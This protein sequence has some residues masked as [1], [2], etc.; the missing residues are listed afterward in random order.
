MYL[1]YSNVGGTI[2]EAELFCMADDLAGSTLLKGLIS[3]YLDPSITLHVYNVERYPEPSRLASRYEQ[4]LQASLPPAL[5]ESLSV[6]S[7]NYYAYRVYIRIYYGTKFLSFYL[8]NGLEQFLPALAIRDRMVLMPQGYGKFLKKM[9]PLKEVGVQYNLH[10]WDFSDEEELTK[11]ISL[12][13][14]EL[15][16]EIR[17]E[18]RAYSSF[19][20]G[21]INVKQVADQLQLPPALLTRVFKEET[22]AISAMYQRLSCDLEQQTLLLGRWTKTVLV[23]RNESDKVFRGVTVK[24]V[25]PIE[26]LPRNI[27]VDLLA[28]SI[29]PIEISIRPLD[30][31]EFPLEISFVL[32]EDRALEDWLPVH[33]IWVQSIVP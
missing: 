30:P 14:K 8:D 31:G 4:L 29:V 26:L 7:M 13:A 9:S 15:Q 22:D 19:I 27:T 17:H 5:G 11:A 10:E 21:V 20:Q 16:Q 32:Q 12:V 2:M 23:V 1:V 6:T 18:V 24:A 25:G 3:T 33:Y 28:H